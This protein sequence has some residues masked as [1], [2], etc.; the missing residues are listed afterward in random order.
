MAKGKAAPCRRRDEGNRPPKCP[1]KCTRKP[2]KRRRQSRPKRPLCPPPCCPCPPPCCP[3]PPPCC[4]CPPPCC[5]CPCPPPYCV[6][7]PC[8]PPTCCPCS[9]PICCPCPPPCCSTSSRPRK[10]P[11]RKPSSCDPCE[12][13]ETFLR[14]TDPSVAYQAD[15]MLSDIKLGLLNNESVILYTVDIELES[16]PS[17]SSSKHPKSS[18]NCKDRHVR[19]PEL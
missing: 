3:C 4:P 7:F 8:S 13:L 19:F 2:A 5:P 10:K 1:P 12:L 9:M 11:R 17:T 16:L 18:S 6:C 15:R 14:H